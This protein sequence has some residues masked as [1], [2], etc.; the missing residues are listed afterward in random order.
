MNRF[1]PLAQALLLLSFAAAEAGAEGS[2]APAGV[3]L[4]FCGDVDAEDVQNALAVEYQDDE[5]GDS[6]LTVHCRGESA[7]LRIVGPTHPRGRIV[8]VDLRGIEAVAKSRTIALLA[9]EL[10]TAPEP[11]SEPASAP[12][13]VGHIAEV[14]T[15]APKPIRFGPSYRHEISVGLGLVQTRRVVYAARGNQSYGASGSFTS[16]AFNADWPIG[17]WIGLFAEGSVSTETRMAGH[18]ELQAPVRQRRSE[19]GFYVPLRRKR[20]RLDLRLSRGTDTLTAQGVYVRN[21]E[22]T[23]L[24]RNTY[25]SFGLDVAYVINKKMN[26]KGWATADAAATTDADYSRVTGFRYGVGLHYQIESN[27]RAG[28]T[29][30]A[31]S[32][33]SGH[34][35]GT[36]SYSDAAT[37]LGVSLTFTR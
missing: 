29:A 16:L 11:D 6:M 22:R 5:L 36:R 12:S 15:P 19:A 17:R 35:V 13:P 26:L 30:D 32:L 23:L 37:T 33:H 4:Q 24:P 25:T 21:S 27:L 31:S 2:P 3:T 9:A 1:I 10:W 8:D 28:A 34:S 20:L 7:T 18:A 14:P